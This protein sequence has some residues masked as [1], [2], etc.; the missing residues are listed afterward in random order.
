MEEK[1]TKTNVNVDISMF[2]IFL[3]II[4]LIW[5]FAGFIG[6]LMSIVCCFYNGSTTDKFLGVLMAWVLGPFYWLFFI[7]NSSYCTRFNIQP[8]QQSYYE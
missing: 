7:Y 8:T 6:F 4:L 3:F 5:W 2:L 1:D